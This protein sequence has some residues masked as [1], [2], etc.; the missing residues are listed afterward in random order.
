M[1][2]L[3]KK[4]QAKQTNERQ[5]K[6][7]P[8]LTRISVSE[9]FDFSHERGVLD[10]YR[11]DAKFEATIKSSGRDDPSFN[12][13]LSNSRGLIINQVFGEFREPL[14]F[15]IEALHDHDIEKALKIASN[16]YSQMFE[17]GI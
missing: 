3:A 5:Y 10:V 11:V 12:S 2:Q 4:I 16:I 13:A 17:E 1:S 6:A 14:Y 7:F 15:L 9:G 8:F